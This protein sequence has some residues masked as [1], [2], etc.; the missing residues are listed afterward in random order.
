MTNS[1]YFQSFEE[2]I[3]SNDENFY[4]KTVRF[5]FNDIFPAPNSPWG[6][7]FYCFTLIIIKMI[8]SFFLNLYASKYGCDDEENFKVIP[9]NISEKILE[10]RKQKSKEALEFLKRIN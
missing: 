4:V 3:K 2:Q 6:I 1:D 7:L 10:R 8:F 9:G 5:I